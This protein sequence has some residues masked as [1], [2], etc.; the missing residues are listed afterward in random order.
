MEKERG[1][2]PCP[3]C[4]KGV[5][6]IRPLSATADLLVIRCENCGRT[7]MREDFRE[8]TDAWND[9]KTDKDELTGWFE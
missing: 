5:L 6:A 3:D 2:R 4:G 8:L 1:F 7:V 9:P